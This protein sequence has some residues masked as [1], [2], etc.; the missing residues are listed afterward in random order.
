M[1]DNGDNDNV[2]NLGWRIAKYDFPNIL[3]GKV[4]SSDEADPRQQQQECRYGDEANRHAIVYLVL[5]A[6]TTFRADAAI[7]ACWSDV[8]GKGSRDGR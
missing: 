2:S 4:H 8:E 3:I 7:R 1:D 5:E 6:S